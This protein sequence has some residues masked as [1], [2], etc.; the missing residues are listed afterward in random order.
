MD[1]WPSCGRFRENEAKLA[2]APGLRHLGFGIHSS[3]VIRHLSLALF[4]FAC[5]LRAAEAPSVDASFAALTTYR[6]G[7]D[8]AA[9]FVL[10]SFANKVSDDSARRAAAAERFAGIVS[11]PQTSDEAK[12]FAV[13]QLKL[14]AGDAQVPLLAKLLDDPKTTD[15]ARLALQTLPGP[16][17][18]EA[19]LAA[20]DRLQGVPLAGVINS[21][22]A[23]RE[24]A[25][26]AKLT[27]LLDSA[28]R[29]VVTATLHALANIGTPAAGK[30]L[31]D[32]PPA[33]A[34][35][36]AWF[37]ALLLA[38]ANLSA[39][40]PSSAYALC[41][42]IWKSTSPAA[43][44]PAALAGIVRADAAK[45]M[46]VLLESLRSTNSVL[47]G[48]AATLVAGLKDASLL[49][50]VAALL[51]QLSP[52][53][54]ALLCDALAA[55]GDRKLADAVLPLTSSQDEPVRLAA[56]SALGR[57]G[58]RA[59]V[60]TLLQFSASEQA[61]IRT[62]ARKSL[63]VLNAPDV[64]TRLVALAAEGPVGGRVEAI[65]AL[66]ARN[67][68]VAV[69]G[70][71]VATGDGDAAVQRAAI[72][73][74]GSLVAPEDYPRLVQLLLT[75]AGKPASQAAVQAVVAASKRVSDN[76]LRVKPAVEAFAVAS[77][78]AKTALLEVLGASG[79]SEALVVVAGALKDADASVREAAL[80]TLAE[81]P[82]ASA[83]KDLLAAAQ[84][85]DSD[86][87]RAKAWSAYV[88]LAL[89]S[90][91]QAAPLLREASAAAQTP[92]DRQSLLAALASADK[93]AALA[94]AT[95]LLSD[96]AIADEAAKVALALAGKFAKSDNEA[97]VNAA[98]RVT[99]VTKDPA[100]IAQAREF[101]TK[102]GTVA[103]ALGSAP[104]SSEAIAARQKEIAAQL[105]AS[106]T[107][108]AY[109]D[110]GVETQSANA[111]GPSLR[112]LNG[113]AW[114]FS[115]SGK[116]S[117][118]QTVAFDGRRLTFELAGLDPQKH[119]AALFTWT[120]ADSGGRS[121][122]VDLLDGTTFQAKPA[123]KQ[124]K[125]P[126][127][128]GSA[129]TVRLPLDPATYAGGK[130]RLAF[131]HLSGPNVAVGELW[132][133][134]TK[135][136]EQAS[137]EERRT[138]KVLIVTGVDYPAHEWR[139]TAPVLKQMLEQGG[140]AEVRVVE[141][142]AF[143]DSATI[144]NYGVVLL[145]FQNWEVPGP[146]AAGRENLKRY[147]ENGG[148][149]VS[150]H[151]AC[152]AWHGEW[153]EFASILGRVWRGSNGTQHDARGPFTVQIVDRD[154]AVTRGLSDFETFDELYTCLVGDVPIH[155]LAQAKSKVDQQNHPQAYVR[156][157]GKGRVFLTTL[158]HDVK[159]FTNN[160][161]VGQ[162]IRQG[163]AWAAGKD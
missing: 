78:A 163:T 120:D 140:A 26:V 144:T 7:Q 146:G 112:Q 75:Q 65:R 111:S 25:A 95:A 153:P 154:H 117:P 47:Q 40:Q 48:V 86:A 21:L 151:F 125:L 156:D 159:A 31:A 129:T 142:P 51:P 148:G 127:G 135:A 81:W 62:A 38:A 68:V 72:E 103:Q 139:K 11:D 132:L 83:A 43:P 147:V 76:A 73:A 44:K 36:A 35:E 121:A 108:L 39:K 8:N 89:E 20:L 79:G 110:A 96:L 52:R 141:D 54:Q 15:D 2:P 98:E 5:L 102:Q 77:P 28:E 6:A 136:G 9:L 109:L 80:E 133:V 93:P 145:H 71:F 23:R 116:A 67:A 158:G 114:D 34:L 49:R 94:A 106:D 131:N 16:R 41:G 27:P 143:L 14:L 90:K 1:R 30:S 12:L 42:Q 10:E 24:A 17:A 22:G 107:L 97:A 155:I 122:S 69:D 88:R 87:V 150:V 105:P 19:L 56:I 149:L 162:L 61:A 160:P 74:L 157:Y 45:A 32:F 124:T 50:K 13:K 82:D 126:A 66:A 100:L 4:F 37:D 99:Q 104:Y 58:S 152:G 70:L 53:G 64:N 128:A 55:T 63:S 118:S 113:K 138:P 115:E 59:Q 161:A 29:V 57:I 123:L 119:Y 130:A 60:E 101:L 33:P 18:T 84:A 137:V 46:P 91:G 3:F 134:E 85:A 92:A